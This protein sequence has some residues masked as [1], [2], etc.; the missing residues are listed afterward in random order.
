MPRAPAD[1]G[2]QRLVSGQT[3]L[4]TY[5]ISLALFGVLSLPVAPWVAPW[6]LVLAL[7]AALVDVVLVEDA[8]SDREEV[9]RPT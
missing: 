9:G 7:V 6:V 5:A 3:V 4:V 8:G 1:D 2:F